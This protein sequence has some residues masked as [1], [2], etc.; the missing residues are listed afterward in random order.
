MVNYSRRGTLVTITL[1]LMAV[2]MATVIGW[3]L[4]QSLNTQPW[5]ANAAA[6]AS[7]GPSIDTHA[8]TFGLI[9]FLAVVTSLFALFFSAYAIR[10]QMVD[11]LPVKEPP[12]LWI[13]TG[14]LVLASFAY[15]WTRSAAVKG[16]TAALKPGLL[17]A[18]LLTFLFLAGQVLAWQ[19]LHGSGHYLSSNPANAFFYVLTAVHG[20][21]MLGGLWVWGRSLQHVFTG[22]EAESVRLSI[23]LCTVYWHYLLLVW[24]VLFALLIST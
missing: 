1:I 11:W 19:Q 12:L 9:T 22:A 6:D 15:H 21:H 23:E 14:F 4:K 18:G 24:V 10:M 20:L 8:K 5:V 16:R 3:L 2:L 7:S 17:I 13:N